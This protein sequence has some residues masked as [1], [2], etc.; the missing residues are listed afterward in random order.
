MSSTLLLL[1]WLKSLIF[2]YFEYFLHFTTLLLILYSLAVCGNII[3]IWFMFLISNRSY[4]I[5]EILD[6]RSMVKL[7]SIGKHFCTIRSVRNLNISVTICFDAVFPVDGIA[8]MNVE[9]NL[10]ISML[11][12][13]FSSLYKNL[14][15]FNQWV[16]LSCFALE[17]CGCYILLLFV[18]VPFSVSSI[19]CDP[20]GNL[21]MFNSHLSHGII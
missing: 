15:K 19:R 12:K 17:G 4:R 13:L 16:R 6:G 20:N 9:I 2:Y 3:F 18:F 11:I 7:T 21:Y 1:I 8:T 5:L 14:L 10:L